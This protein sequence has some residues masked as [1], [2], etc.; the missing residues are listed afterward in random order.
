MNQQNNFKKIADNFGDGKIDKSKP[1]IFQYTIYSDTRK[2]NKEA[3]EL[4]P[5]EL[6]K[7]IAYLEMY[8]LNGKLTPK[9]YDVSVYEYVGFLRKG[10]K[11]QVTFVRT[12]NA[13]NAYMGEGD[14]PKGRYNTIMF[15]FY[16]NKDLIKRSDGS[17]EFRLETY[18]YNTKVY[19]VGKYL[20]K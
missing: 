2:H 13:K 20:Q 11:L 10:A 4:L 18:K 3:K 12:N 1:S 6:N 9:S 17:P 5:E 7:M 15:D 14:K 16:M 8:V 19:D